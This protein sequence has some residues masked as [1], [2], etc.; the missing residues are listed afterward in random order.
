MGTGSCWVPDEGEG[1]M[2][3]RT[4]CFP[5]VLLGTLCNLD[6]FSLVKEHHCRHLGP[7]LLGKLG[8]AYKPGSRAG[9]RQG[10]TGHKEQL[11]VQKREPPG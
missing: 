10:S 5:V 1:Q 4:A 11:P 9:Q 6:A 3:K 2:E 8:N 7:C